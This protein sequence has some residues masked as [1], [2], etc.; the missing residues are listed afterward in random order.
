[1]GRRGTNRKVATDQLPLFGSDG[2]PS[3]PVV[4]ARPESSLMFVLR[5]TNP[6]A[7]R[8]HEDAATH[9]A[10][11]RGR[12]AY[13]PHLL[14]MSLLCMGRF[15][16]PPSRLIERAGAIAAGIQARPIPITLDSAGLFGNSRH[17]ALYRPKGNAMVGQFVRMLGRAL[18]QH[19]LP[20]FQASALMPHVTLAYD[21]RNIE[22]LPL[23]RNYA[24]ISGEFMLVYSYHGQ[25][26]HEE[27]GRWAFDPK[28]VPYP[29]S[30]EQLRLMV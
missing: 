21:C 8:M 7:L 30:F 16:K 10:V 6:V 13:P 23:T 29:P 9:L 15:D 1:M 11:Q 18:A 5:P 4:P 25:T 3:M 20:S 17:L 24:W 14:H 27:L 12:D 22:P 26:R 28:A 19:N 2:W